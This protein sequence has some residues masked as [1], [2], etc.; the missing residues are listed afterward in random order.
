MCVLVIFFLSLIFQISLYS[1]RRWESRW[2][3][4]RKLPNH[5]NRSIIRQEAVSRSLCLD[6]NLHAYSPC[7]CGVLHMHCWVCFLWVVDISFII[8]LLGFCFVLFFVLFCFVCLFVFCLYVCLFYVRKRC[9]CFMVL[10]LYF[11]YT[12]TFK[13]WNRVFSGKDGHAEKFGDIYDSHT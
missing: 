6:T 4:L 3:V 8:Y 7:K 10:V 13:C 12:C 2:S 5:T 11:M 9:C 1:T